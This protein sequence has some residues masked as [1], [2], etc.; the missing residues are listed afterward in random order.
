MRRGGL[1][2]AGLDTRPC[3]D[4]SAAALAVG[5]R[6]RRSTDSRTSLRLLDGFAVTVAGQR[7]ILP[8][9]VQRLLAYLAVVGC[10]SRSAIAGALWPET[11]DRQSRGALRTSLWRIQKLVPGLLTVSSWSVEFSPSATIDVSEF[12]DAAHV[13][14]AE[15]TPKWA[16]VLAVPLDW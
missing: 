14:L 1:P 13:V 11:L 16:D 15:P 8:A 10:T 7:M 12:L 6:P 5:A 2:V 4:A 9:Q 3:P